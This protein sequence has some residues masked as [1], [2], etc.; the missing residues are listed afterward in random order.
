MSRAYG[1][2]AGMALPDRLEPLCDLLLGA[3]YADA[4]FK[5]RE[6]EE[7][8][9]MLVDL[10][11]PLSPEL[12]KRI[13]TF[14]PKKFDMAKSA[15]AFKADAEDDKKRLLFLV[16]AINEADEEIDM[17]EDEYLRSLAK[18]LGLPDSA[19]EGMTVNI[20]EDVELDVVFDAVVKKA[21]PPPPK[22]K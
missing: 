2:L 17:A 5:D 9:G 8:K 21:P 15:A 6:R 13:D 11:G 19:L 20:E 22:R 3:A 1:I 12:E 7:V 10:G 18:A 4:E 14:D 16:S